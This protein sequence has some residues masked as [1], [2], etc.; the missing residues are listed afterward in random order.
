[1]SI[2][3]YIYIYIYIHILLKYFKGPLAPSTKGPSPYRPR[4]QGHHFFHS[5]GSYLRVIL[6]ILTPG[7]HYYP[8]A[9]TWAP[10]KT[11]NMFYITYVY[12]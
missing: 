10:P 9:M 12:Q 5:L 6:G 2:C 11:D 4:P 3:L 7:M 8:G 1:M